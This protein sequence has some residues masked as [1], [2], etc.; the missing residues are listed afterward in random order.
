LSLAGVAA[1]GLAEADDTRV[2]IPIPVDGY[3]WLIGLLLS[4]VSLSLPRRRPCLALATAAF[5]AP[6]VY[7]ARVLIA[8]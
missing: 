8:G 7:L 6:V 1:Q 4:L 3:V 2:T 5:A